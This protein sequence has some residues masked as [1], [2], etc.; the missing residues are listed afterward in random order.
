MRGRKTALKIVLTA[1]QRT[2]LE[3][4]LLPHHPY[5]LAGRPR[6]YPFCATKVKDVMRALAFDL[7]SNP[8]EAEVVVVGRDPEMTYADLAAATQALYHGAK[9]LALNLDARVPVDGG[10]LLPGNG[11]IVAAL[12]EATGTDV[13]AIGKPAP[14]FFTSA[15][16][17]FGAVPERTAMV[18]D[19]LDSDI[20]GG[21][22]AGLRTIHVGGNDYT[23][24]PT[25]PKPD[26]RL[27]SLHQLVDLLQAS[28]ACR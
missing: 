12:R 10:I 25:A 15:L 8:N 24:Q 7:T 5:F 9:L 4:Q 20:L 22:Q 14:F 11:A 28:E 18:G 13:E 1:E 23:T 2:F 19:T 26:L 6:V 3:T 27:D 17:T 16:E 21:I